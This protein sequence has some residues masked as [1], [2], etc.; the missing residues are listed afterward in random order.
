M[1]TFSGLEALQRGT[2]SGAAGS[3]S[4]IDGGR[5]ASRIVCSARA[6]LRPVWPQA[7]AR[8]EACRDRS[9]Q[10]A[11]NTRGAHQAWDPC[12]QLSK[13]RWNPRLRLLFRWIFL[14]R[15][16]RLNRCHHLNH[17]HRK[18]IIAPGAALRA[19]IDLCGWFFL[20]LRLIF[21]DIC[22]IFVKCSC[23][24]ILMGL[25]GRA[26]DEHAGGRDSFD[27]RKLSVWP[28]SWYTG[29]DK[30]IKV[31][32][33]QGEVGPVPSSNAI[34]RNVSMLSL[35]SE[36]VWCWSFHVVELD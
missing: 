20:K 22:F 35:N 33:K 15:E 36:L 23:M 1:L 6:A 31:I 29:A 26:P 13:I 5:R 2:E 30:W 25:L 27:P 8:H 19:T 32:C 12:I 16:L 34:N 28:S 17:H 24:W 9:L 11:K 14:Y 18:S 10:E 4:E 21:A 7:A 3:C